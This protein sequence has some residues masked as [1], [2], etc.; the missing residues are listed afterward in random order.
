R[1]GHAQP[2]NPVEFV[3]LRLAA[4]GRLARERQPFVPP[5]PAHTPVIGEREVIVGGQTLRAN[6]INRALLTDRA[7]YSGPAVIEE[8]SATTFGPPGYGFRLDEWGNL[9]IRRDA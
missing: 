1:F 8:E 2:G 7:G 4:V 5:P 9:L 3:N 6:I